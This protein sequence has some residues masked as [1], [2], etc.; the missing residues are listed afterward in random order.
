MA[1]N[2]E[3]R[4][5]MPGVYVTDFRSNRPSPSTLSLSLPAEHKEP[6]ASHT[7]DE[8]TSSRS[9]VLGPSSSSL[10]PSTSTALSPDALSDVSQ[11]TFDLAALQNSTDHLIASNAEMVEALE[12]DGDEDGVYGEAIRDN[13]ATIERQ[14]RRAEEMQRLIEDALAGHAIDRPPPHSTA[15]SAPTQPPPSSTASSG[16]EESG[17]YL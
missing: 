7:S 5:L 6:F 11:L 2:A 9:T 14:Q 8:K 16:A 17:M 12:E 13:M 4:E 3:E 10:S 15:A 1:D